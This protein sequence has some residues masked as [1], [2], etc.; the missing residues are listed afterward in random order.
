M[1]QAVVPGGRG[2]EAVVPPPP[3]AAA[4]GV[5]T[6]LRVPVKPLSVVETS[7]ALVIALVEWKTAMAVPD[8][9]LAEGELPHGLPLYT[10]LFA[11]A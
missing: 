9:V 3:L 6:H 4:A 10:M 5:S 1:Y 8:S 2:A 7:T 11:K